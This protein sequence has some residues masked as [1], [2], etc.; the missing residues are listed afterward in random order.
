MMSPAQRSEHEMDLPDDRRAQILAAAERLLRHYGWQKTTVADIARE[1]HVAVGSVYLEFTSKSLIMQEISHS[2]HEHVLRAMRRA[3]MSKGDHGERLARLFEARTQALLEISQ[4]DAHARDALAC[5]CQGVQQA[6]ARFERAQRE[7]LTDFIAAAQH[8][9]VFAS[10]DVASTLEALL[11]A[12]ARFTPPALF[13]FSSPQQLQS[14]LEAM[15]RLVLFGL[16][17][18]P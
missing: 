18:R 12:Y 1:A 7:L 8:D 9:G 16:L 4:S 5:A 15:H 13:S 17:S 6:S 3:T 2:K 10:C 11:T 14:Q